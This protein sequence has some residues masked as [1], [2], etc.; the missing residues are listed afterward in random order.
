MANVQVKGV[1]CDGKHHELICRWWVQST[2]TMLMMSESQQQ[3]EFIADGSDEEKCGSRPL[4]GRWAAGRA[5][6]GRRNYPGT[7]TRRKLLPTLRNWNNRGG[8]TWYGRQS[9]WET[10]GETPKL[11]GREGLTSCPVSFTSPFPAKTS[12]RSNP[13]RNHLEGEPGG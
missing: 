12:H 13:T 10:E 8:A 4:I 6:Q 7:S 1:Q 5:Q 2:G 11:R 3:I 9:Q